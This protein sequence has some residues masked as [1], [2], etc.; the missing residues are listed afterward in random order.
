MEKQRQGC[1][2]VSLDFELYWGMRDKC[3]ME[4]YQQNL[5]GVDGAV[6][7]LL[8][9]FQ[10]N[11]IHATWATV[12]FLFAKDRA[13]LIAHEPAELP[14]Y[15]DPSLQPYQYIDDAA[16]L[17]ERFHFSFELIDLIN[18]TQGQE[19]GSHT[20]SHYYCMEKGQTKKQF[21][22][23][24]SA[25]VAIAHDHGITLKSLVLPRNQWNEA[26]R[27]VLIECGITCYR[28]NETNF[29]YKSTDTESQ[30]YFIRA[31]R[32]MDAYL[33]L[34]GNHTYS[35]QSCHDHGLFNFPASRF[36]RPYSKTFKL[37]EPL[38]M[39][40]IKQGMTDA[41]KHGKIF[42][43]WWH[44]HNFGANTEENMAFLKGILDHYR[45]LK[46]Q[47]GMCSLNMAELV[48]EC[49]QLEPE[50]SSAA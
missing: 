32:L 11:D 14:S 2:T 1:F 42:H 25:A 44:P 17:D 12:G 26:Y 35:Y 49:R 33:C 23:D 48:A 7:S 22:G 31:L 34:T 10:Q 4:A 19:V 47:Y 16:E 8:D 13:D 36:L 41:A 21:N 15:S 24:M 28:G 37:L 9:L 6:R 50:Q 27:E 39:H 40:R 29:L 5:L 30:S 46:E 45:S 38:R 18:N 3:T 43:L 20:F